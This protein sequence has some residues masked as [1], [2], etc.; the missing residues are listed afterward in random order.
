MGCDYKVANT[1]YFAGSSNMSE[2]VIKRKR[3]VQ[4]RTLAIGLVFLA[5]TVW[6]LWSS[7][8]TLSAWNIIST[9]AA[10]LVTFMI[11]IASRQLLTKKPALVL[12]DDGLTDYITAQPAGFIPWSAIRGSRLERLQAA[13][14]LTIDLYNPALVLDKLTD[15][16]RKTLEL[17]MKKLGTPLVVPIRLVDYEPE[18]LRELIAEMAR[19]D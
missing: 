12:T 11:A 18:E 4:A 1:C 7:G 10:G 5:L 16:K 19:T 14:V 8:F 17:P 15:F 2:L 9:L 6:Q 3:G 13:P